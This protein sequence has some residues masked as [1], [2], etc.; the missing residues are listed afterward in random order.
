MTNRQPGLMDL[1]NSETFRP[2]RRDA[3]LARGPL[4]YVPRTPQ[5][6]GAF[7]NPPEGWWRDRPVPARADCLA[8]SLRKPRTN[9]EGASGAT[10]QPGI[11]SY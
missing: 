8:P 6:V 3:D 9:T 1:P 11:S 5:A 2:N 4:A 7:S 10:L